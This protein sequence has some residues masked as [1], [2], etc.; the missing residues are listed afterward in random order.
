ML[1]HPSPLSIILIRGFFLILAKFCRPYKIFYFKDLKLKKNYSYFAVQNKNA[2]PP[3]KIFSIFISD[4]ILFSKKTSKGSSFT[5]LSRL[6]HIVRITQNEIMRPF[7]IGL[8]CI[9]AAV[10]VEEKYKI[11]NGV[12]VF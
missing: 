10:C 4:K 12:S 11:F 5:F 1:R 8:S 9:R 2:A 7:A 6:C 3:L